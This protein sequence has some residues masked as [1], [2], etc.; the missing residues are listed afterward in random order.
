MRPKI[1]VLR[2]PQL[3]ELLFL[4]NSGYN[5]AQKIHNKTEKQPS[6]IVQ[7]LKKI[8]K[9]G[10]LNLRK[11]PLLNKKIYS[12]N[13]NKITQEFLDFLKLKIE[14]NKKFLLGQYKGDESRLKRIISLAHM[15]Y[16]EIY[17]KKFQKDILSNPYLISTFNKIFNKLS[18]KN[19]KISLF[20]LFEKLVMEKFFSIMYFQITK[21]TTPIDTLIKKN[22]DID[23]FLILLRICSFA[24]LD[25][26]FRDILDNVKKE[27][28]D[29]LIKKI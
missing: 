15:N 21:T 28:S 24:Q 19:K 23:N 13:W 16:K 27:I 29:E 7:Q 12:I 6:P 17:D 5:Y 11:D 8:N 25:P 26:I 22:K 9:E 1:K 4:I 18:Y 3:T 2:S 20:D 10:Y 14:E